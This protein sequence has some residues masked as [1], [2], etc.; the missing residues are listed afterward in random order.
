MGEGPAAGG[1]RAGGWPTEIS[2]SED[3]LSSLGAVTLIH[4]I[5]HHH[6]ERRST[7]ESYALLVSPSKGSSPGLL[8][9]PYMT[10]SRRWAGRNT[11][12]RKPA[13]PPLRHPPR[14][15]RPRPPHLPPRWPRNP[16]PSRLRADHLPA[17]AVH[18][19]R[20]HSLPHTWTRPQPRQMYTRRSTVDLH[21]LAA[22]APHPSWW[23]ALHPAD[24]RSL[25]PVPP[26]ELRHVLPRPPP[27]PGRGALLLTHSCRRPAARKTKAAAV[28]VIAVLPT[29]AD[30]RP[31]WRCLD[32]RRVLKQVKVHLLDV[33]RHKV[34]APVL[35][36][37]KVCHRAVEVDLSP[38]FR[39]AESADLVVPSRGPTAGVW[40]PQVVQA[41][42]QKIF[43]RR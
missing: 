16:A 41:L 42:P 25:R 13:E 17:A 24:P 14:P 8:R 6:N 10:A 32:I 35:T 18:H 31:P 20:S 9:H 3:P 28:L 30:S 38:C 39:L 4:V 23:P 26:D 19:D 33:S 5:H 11:P 22:P 29:S 1:G 27:F 34:V 12:A 15:R 7:V 37:S 21:Q 43:A 36:P 40:P 2:W